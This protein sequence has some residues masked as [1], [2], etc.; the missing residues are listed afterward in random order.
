MTERLKDKVALITGA[1]SGQGAAE[2]KLFLAEGA[3]VIATDA[4]TKLLNKH[5]D[6]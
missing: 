1:A 2:L 6:E 4:N 5:A 3:K